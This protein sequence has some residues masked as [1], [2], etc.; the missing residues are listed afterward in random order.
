MLASAV[1]D[2]EALQHAISTAEATDA[3]AELVSEARAALEQV[4]PH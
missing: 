3:Q 2:T 4:M 1:S